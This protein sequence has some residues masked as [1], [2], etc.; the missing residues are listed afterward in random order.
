V[1]QIK[2]H[3]MVYGMRVQK[4]NKVMCSTVVVVDVV[5]CLLR[6]AGSQA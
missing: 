3:P 2:S 4:K 6:N 1:N 5:V